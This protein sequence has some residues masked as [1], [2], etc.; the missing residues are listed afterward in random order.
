MHGVAEK[1]ADSGHTYMAADILF[2]AYREGDWRGWDEE[3][4]EEMGEELFELL[5]IR[6]LVR[7]SIGR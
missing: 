3:E 5:K 1:L 2:R 6:T 7:L 4:M